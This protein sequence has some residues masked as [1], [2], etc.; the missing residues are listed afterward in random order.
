MSILFTLKGDN[1]IAKKKGFNEYRIVDDYVIIYLK[2]RDGR[3]FETLIDLEDLER[4]KN[5]GLHWCEIYNPKSKSSYAQSSEYIGKTD[6][7]FRSKTHF[8]NKEI[9]QEFKLQVDHYNHDTLDNRKYNLFIKTNQQNLVNRRGANPNSTTKI[10]NVSWSE[11][12]QRYLV[13]FQ[14][15]RKNTCFGRFKKE[16]FDK[17]VELADK[18]RKELYEPLYNG[19]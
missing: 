8:L 18:L 14:V 17:A 7:G 3:V 2:K 12:T 9:M 11:S 19:D 10:R 1:Q 5:L 13:Q 6:K 16:E 15:N 4:I